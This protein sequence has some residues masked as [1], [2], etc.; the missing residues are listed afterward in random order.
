MW[1]AEPAD[2]SLLHFLFYVHS[3]G[4]I[5]TLISTD[6][7]AQQHRIVGGSQLIAQRAAERLGDRVVLNAPV[8]R[9][10]DDGESVA[11][12]GDGVEAHGAHVDRRA[13]A[14]ARRAHRLRARPAGVAR[15]A[16][17]ARA[18]RAR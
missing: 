16:D 15:P 3:G 5:D 11:V 17:P 8:S 12:Y 1:A 4:G 10:V 2:L 18:A 9:I 6:G 7:G 13:P 14:D